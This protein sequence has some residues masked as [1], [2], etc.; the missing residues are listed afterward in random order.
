MAALNVHLKQIS[1][2]NIGFQSDWK[3]QILKQIFLKKEKKTVTQKKMNIT[4][5]EQTVEQTNIHHNLG[6]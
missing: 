6:D 3:G 1:T 4:V 5:Q 2:S